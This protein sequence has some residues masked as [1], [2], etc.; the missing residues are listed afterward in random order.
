MHLHVFRRAHLSGG[1]TEHE[2]TKREGMPFF[3]DDNGVAMESVNAFLDH[4]PRS[5]ARSPATWLAY[6]R[7]LQLW[8]TWLQH[9]DVELFAGGGELRAHLD[10]Y[11]AH[12]LVDGPPS[13]R[14]AP[15][16]WNRS[17][18]SLTRFYAWA[19]DEGH[20]GTTPFSFKAVRIPARAS[21]RRNQ[22][23]IRDAAR[24]SKI[25]WLEEDFLDLFVNVGMAGLL[26]TG[27]EDESFHGR[28]GA[29]NRALA[30][31]AAASGMRRQEFSHLLAWELPALPRD[32]RPYISFELPPPIC[33]NEQGRTTWIT[34]SALRVAH[35][36]V[37]LERQ[38]SAARSRWQPRGQAL[39]VTDP[40]PLGGRINGRAVRWSSLTCE[41]RLRLVAPGGGGSTVFLSS[42]GAPVLAWE[43]TF[44]AAT[45]RC[46]AVEPNFP[47]VTPHMLRHTFAV[48]TLRWLVGRQ[49]ADLNS[50]YARAGEDPAWLA[51]LRTTDPLMVL[52][53]LMGHASVSTTEV[54][55]KLIDT[56]RLF[57]D[58]PDL[59]TGVTADPPDP[60]ERP[61]MT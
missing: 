34:P 52:R 57:T 55:L 41:E 13:A 38:V 18:Q 48:H 11:Y 50:A 60:F 14:Y 7:D 56:A 17:M 23:K 46:R 3:L 4:L 15:A 39:H 44:R 16:S 21:A 27:G 49:L 22:S 19:V 32:N 6:A 45:A 51:A 26:P 2:V 37:R 5:G 30:A 47:D 10:A 20:L 42:G 29:R 8:A 53:D 58:A 61:A 59:V 1:Q 24:H 40:T 35:E 31:C 9:H 28:N 54:Y 12:R 36:Y 33:K 43:D 25:H